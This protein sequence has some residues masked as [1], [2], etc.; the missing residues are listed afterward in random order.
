MC[1]K[2]ILGT[3]ALAGIILTCF[4]VIIFVVSTYDYNKF[5]P[6]IT[7]IAQ[8]YTGRK[9]TITGDI[10]VKLSLSP[11]F[12]VNN[13]SFQNA[14]WSYYPEMINAKKIEVQLALIPLI[15][16]N[17]NVK[18]L[19]LLNPDLMIEVNAA[20]KT[21]L[22]FDLPEKKKVQTAPVK[23]DEVETALFDFKEVLIKDGKLTVE[24]H[25]K[26][27]PLV[28]TIDQG[29]RKSAKFMGDGDIELR[30]S[31]NDIPLNMSGKIGS[32]SGITDP[33]VTDPLDLKGD[34]DKIKFAISGKIQDPITA[35][36]ID[37][38][39]S[40]KGD[41]LSEIENIRQKPLPIKGPFNFS[42]HLIAAKPEKIQVFDM[43][44]ELGSS[45][46]NGSVTLDRSGEK[47]RVSG[48]LF[49]EILDLRQM[50]IKREKIAADAEK[51]Q[52]N[53]FK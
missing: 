41:D 27:P 26:K 33:D 7:G 22:E 48:D 21:N 3:G 8:K 19:T 30:G 18:R 12:Q 13:V 4:L 47:P 16:G 44:I 43:L 49:S 14:P 52:R 50:L 42:S 15:K 25:Q 32:L 31:F 35:K 45:K 34:I 28:L 20:G 39:F 6:M 17:I 10:K 2:I 1:R 38:K 36:G 40:V 53:L 51:K 5:K 23:K 11:S 29:S 37:V 24:N 9:L 46:L